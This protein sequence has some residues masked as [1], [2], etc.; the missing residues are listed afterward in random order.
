MVLIK[1]MRSKNFK[2]RLLIWSLIIFAPKNPSITKAINRIKIPRP[3]YLCSIGKMR[4]KESKIVY[5]TYPVMYIGRA[6][7]KPF[8]R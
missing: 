6:S 1:G 2:K 3:G 5:K 8:M 7:T 4:S